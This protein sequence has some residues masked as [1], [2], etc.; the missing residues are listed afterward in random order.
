MS[1]RYKQVDQTEKKLYGIVAAIVESVRDGSIDI[2]RVFTREYASQFGDLTDQDVLVELH[3]SWYDSLPYIRSV[4][5][6][7]ITK[8]LGS[9]PLADGY[10]VNGAEVAC[11]VLKNIFADFCMTGE[12]FLHPEMMPGFVPN[13]LFD[14]K[15]LWRGKEG[16]IYVPKSGDYIHFSAQSNLISE[17]LNMIDPNQGTDLLQFNE[18]I[19]PWEGEESEEEDA[20]MEDDDT[21][22]YD[23]DDDT[24]PNLEPLGIYGFMASLIHAM[25]K[26]AVRRKIFNVDWYDENWAL[27]VPLTTG[28]I[29]IVGHDDL[30]KHFHVPAQ[31]VYTDYM[32]LAFPILS[33]KLHFEDIEYEDTPE[34]TLQKMLN[35]ELEQF[36]KQQRSK[37]W[38]VLP[39]EVQEML[40]K[41]HVLFIKHL[42]KR[43]GKDP[44]GVPEEFF[45]RQ[46]EEPQ[47]WAAAPQA[48]DTPDKPDSS[49]FD[50]SENMS[51]E[52]C[53][54]ELI[55]IFKNTK[56]KAAA[57]NE[58]MKSCTAGY[59]LLNDKTYQERASL[60]TPWARYLG[61]GYTFTGEDFR[62]AQS[63]KAKKN[64]ARSNI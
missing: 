26:D 52:A 24:P 25:L 2:H 56:S 15:D 17:D 10:L 19:Q 58:L 39:A 47:Q 29:K 14:A 50:I 20:P 7:N 53:E 13:I 55:R 44:V 23:E 30:P 41:Y 8:K 1:K 48:T 22:E 33:N 49:F 4:Q 32:E 21:P 16:F 11:F 12:M 62:K 38:C 42:Q 37:L 31:V 6:K 43:L 5:D 61:K 46:T 34:Y 60:L 3:K 51:Y 54:K 36:T 27:T 57:C 28:Q 18:V 45:I 9:F 64:K 59:F 63:N 35:I 40:L